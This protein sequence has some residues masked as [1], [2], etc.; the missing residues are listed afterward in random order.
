MS[1]LTSVKVRQPSVIFSFYWHSVKIGTLLSSIRRKLFTAWECVANLISGSLAR[2]K[3]SAMTRGW[4]V[5]FPRL[6]R[7]T[8]TTSSTA[9]APITPIS[10]SSVNWQRK[11]FDLDT[12]LILTPLKLNLLD[13]W[14]DTNHKKLFTRC[15][16][17]FVPG[18]AGRN[19]VVQTPFTE[20]QSC[21]QISSNF[22]HTFISSSVELNWYRHWRSALYMAP[23]GSSGNEYSSISPGTSFKHLP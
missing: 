15:F 8:C 11:I 19:K 14:L 21:E 9:F 7:N 2:T 1:W 20:H 5:T 13:I 23:G 17:H 18:A 3:I 10:P 16:P 6:F 4:M 12:L 22:E